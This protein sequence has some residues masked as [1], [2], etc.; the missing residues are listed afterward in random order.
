MKQ[1]KREK[2]SENFHLFTFFSLRLFVFFRLSINAI[3]LNKSATTFGALCLQHAAFG[4][5]MFSSK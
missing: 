1:K 5:R 4:I 2:I 3:V